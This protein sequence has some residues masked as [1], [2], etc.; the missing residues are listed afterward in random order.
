MDGWTIGRGGGGRWGGGEEGV[1][2]GQHITNGMVVAQAD[3]AGGGVGASYKVIII[4][5]IVEGVLSK[6]LGK[7]LS[8]SS[9]SFPPIITHPRSSSL[10]QF[11]LHKL[12]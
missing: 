1:G 3:S 11:V 10:C 7:E 4:K 8:V 9:S 5:R 6:S 12:S 2:R